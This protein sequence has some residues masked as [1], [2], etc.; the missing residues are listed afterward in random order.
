MA[1]QEFVIE[2][3]LLPSGLER[4]AEVPTYHVEM[5]AARMLLQCVAL[6]ALKGLLKHCSVET[7]EK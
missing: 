3:K 2:S 7:S 4:P 1:S 5:A 6:R